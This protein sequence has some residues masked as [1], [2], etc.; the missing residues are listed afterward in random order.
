MQTVGTSGALSTNASITRPPLTLLAR[1]SAIRL[2]DIGD[3]PPIATAGIERP[4][5]LGDDPQPTVD[6]SYAE[7]DRQGGTHEAV[8]V[9]G[10]LCAEAVARPLRSD[11]E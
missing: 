11:G 8:A 6:L 3:E 1:R 10:L 2:E 9:E 4:G 7:P 5:A